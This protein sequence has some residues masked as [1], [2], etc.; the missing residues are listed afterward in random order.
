[1]PLNSLTAAQLLAPLGPA[2]GR[3]LLVTG[4]AGGVGGY[5]VGLAAHTGWAVTGLARAFDADFLSRAGAVDMITS[6]ADARGFD[7]V[8]DA[9]LL[10][11]AALRAV[12]DH[13]TYVGVYPGA[14]PEV[15]RGITITTGV[16]TPD[17][18]Q[19]RTILELTAQGVLE[20]RRAGN[21]PLHQAAR[22]YQ[23]LRSG[24]QRGRWVL[25]P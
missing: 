21:V 20:A 12:R 25:T 4:A 3:R 16:V 22:A 9:A 10:N 6:P 17:G 11:G 24:G 15:E 18:G 5:A 14:E 19:L 23:S 2:E 7:A 13:G 8:L 1:M